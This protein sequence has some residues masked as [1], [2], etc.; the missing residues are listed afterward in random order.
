MGLASMRGVSRFAESDPRRLFIESVKLAWSF[1][2]RMSW[3]LVP[4]R[5]ATRFTFRM[6]IDAAVG[7]RWVARAMLRR[8]DTQMAKD[9]PA[10]AALF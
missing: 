5:E 4:V 7:V 3:D 2:I 10:L 6:E 8:Y 1:F 9:V